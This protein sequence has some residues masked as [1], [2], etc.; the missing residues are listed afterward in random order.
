MLDKNGKPYKL[1]SSPNPLVSEQIRLPENEL[2]FHNFKFNPKIVNLKTETYPK[3]IKEPEPIKIEEPLIKEEIIKPLIIEPLIEDIKEEPIINKPLIEEEI[4]EEPLIDPEIPQEGIILVHCHP[5]LENNNFGKKFIFEAYIVESNDI[6]ICLYT[7]QKNIPKG[8]IL[9]P[10]K[11]KDGE[12]LGMLRWWKI[13]SI[14]QQDDEFLLF[15][16]ITNEQRSF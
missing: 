6:E 5:L 13:S 10:S 2:I 7:K 3:S 15:G 12:K 16:Q 9:Y 11:Y 1:F 8:S 14:K 4:A